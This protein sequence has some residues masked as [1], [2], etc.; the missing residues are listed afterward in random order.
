MEDSLKLHGG[1]WNISGEHQVKQISE[2]V[3]NLYDMAGTKPRPLNTYTLKTEKTTRPSFA[4]T[5]EENIFDFLTAFICSLQGSKTPFR[6]RRIP[7]PRKLQTSKLWIRDAIP[8]PDVP[9]VSLQ[10]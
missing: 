4:L 5:Q 8:P 9:A 10:L 7:I 6:R 1:V 2:G 3:H